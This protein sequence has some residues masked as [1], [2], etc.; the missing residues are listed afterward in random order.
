[1]RGWQIT[2]EEWLALACHVAGA[3][4]LI[5]WGLYEWVT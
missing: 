4:V 1:M 3:M 2:G 5:S